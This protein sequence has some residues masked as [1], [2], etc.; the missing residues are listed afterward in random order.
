MPEIGFSA[1]IAQ[2]L[3]I[4]APQI[5]RARNVLEGPNLD[6]WYLLVISRWLQRDFWKFSFFPVFWGAAGEKI[7]IFTIFSPA[8]PW[9]TAKNENFQ[10]SLWS[11]L[12][13]TMKY[14]WSKSELSRSFLALD[15]CGA[16]ILRYCAICAKNPFS[17]VFWSNSAQNFCFSDK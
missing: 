11:H 4:T 13:I 17:S 10:K 6:Q 9:K 7:A 5:S 1:H 3:K 2:Y 14:H 8:A 16:V 12:D 15:I